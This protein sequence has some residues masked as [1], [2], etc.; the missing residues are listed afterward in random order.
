MQIFLL[1]IREEYREWYNS[2]KLQFTQKSA[3]KESFAP[4]N[5]FL[6]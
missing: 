2:C 4:G 6:T 5:N 3:E 1:K